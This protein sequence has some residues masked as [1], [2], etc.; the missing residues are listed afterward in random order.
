MACLAPRRKL[1]TGKMDVVGPG[2]GVPPG[3]PP[4]VPAGGV[5]RPG[6]D[7]RLGLGDGQ[8]DEVGD[9]DAEHLA[10]VA[11]QL[12]HF[13]L[14]AELEVV[15]HVAGVDGDVVVGLVVHEVV[16]VAVLV[17]VGHLTALD[18][19]LG[20]LGSVLQHTDR[21]FNRI[22]ISWSWLSSPRFFVSK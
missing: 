3:H 7:A 8:F 4:P 20:E 6:A 1:D 2:T 5:V 9:L 15:G 16:Q 12:A 18:E 17:A 19:R 10:L 22:C 21:L 11:Q 14:L 13:V